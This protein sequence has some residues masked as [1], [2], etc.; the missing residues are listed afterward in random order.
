MIEAAGVA[1]R[2]NLDSLLAGTA[3]TTPAFRI[4]VDG[5]GG[6]VGKAAEVRFDAADLYGTQGPQAADIRQDALGAPEKMISFG[7]QAQVAGCAMQKAHAQPHLQTQHDLG[8]RRRREPEVARR[9][10][11]APAID[12][13]HESGEFS[14]TIDRARAAH[15][16]LI[17]QSVGPAKGIVGCSEWN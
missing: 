7:C 15:L 16:C 5:G 17:V 6:T 8:H 9:S 12:R 4:P 2:F 3:V 13:R 10:R 1:S 14:G 11:E